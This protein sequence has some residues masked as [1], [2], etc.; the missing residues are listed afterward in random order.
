MT[1]EYRDTGPPGETDGFPARRV[2]EEV[3]TKDMR[4][5]SALAMVA[6][7]ALALA[8]AAIGCGKKDDES[9]TTTTET[10]STMPDTS[11]MHDSMMVDTSVHQ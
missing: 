5:I 7:L 3:N 10:P 9:T 11:T 8:L 6:F 2:R 4:K 1:F